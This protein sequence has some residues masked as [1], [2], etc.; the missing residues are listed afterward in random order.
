M[1]AAGVYQADGDKAAYVR[2]LGFSSLQHEQLVLNY[3]RTHRAIRRAEVIELCRLSDGQAK[4]LLKRM[5]TDGI[6]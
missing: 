3:V 4:D 5:K 2:Q 6:G 1:M